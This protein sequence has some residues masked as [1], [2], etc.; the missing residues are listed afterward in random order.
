VARKI[1]KAQKVALE[2]RLENPTSFTVKSV[3]SQGARKD[4]LTAKVSVMP[5]AAGY[6]EPFEVGG[7]HKLNG[8]ALLNP[9]NVKLN[10]HG[11][12]P[13]NKLSQ[14]KGKEDTF[15]GEVSTRYGENVNGV[16][17]RKKAKKVK[18]NKRRLKRSSN[19]TRRP[20]QKQ[21][22]PKLLIRF[23][24]ALPVDPVLGYQE[25]A[26]QMAQSLMPAAISQALDEAI[27]T[28]K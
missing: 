24:D 20:R 23:G 14:L 25:R 26:Q 2:R 27:R 4:N 1:E 11:N 12:L 7:V 3:R 5:T 13:R 10:K 17:R 18:K 8:A 19:G 22:P 9:K 6:L 21:R 28:A 16:W 15:I